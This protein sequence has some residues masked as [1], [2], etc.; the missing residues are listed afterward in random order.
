MLL[1]GGRTEGTDYLIADESRYGIP[2]G[3][4]DELKPDYLCIWNEAECVIARLP[5][6]RTL[7]L[8]S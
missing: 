6:N 5:F 1:D 3:I 7:L 4:A 2:V 8:A